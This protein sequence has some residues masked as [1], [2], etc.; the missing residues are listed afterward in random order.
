MV[1]V[2]QQK[3]VRHMTKIMVYAIHEITGIVKM[4]MLVEG[5]IYPAIYP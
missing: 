4:L 5:E 3:L 1:T 2:P